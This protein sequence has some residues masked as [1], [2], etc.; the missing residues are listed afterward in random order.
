MA[1]IHH[2]KYIR[3]IATIFLALGILLASSGFSVSLHL[4]CGQVQSISV[5]AVADN[6]GE[7][8]MPANRVEPGACCQDL[9][10]QSQSDDHPATKSFVVEKTFAMDGAFPAAMAFVPNSIPRAPNV[11]GAEYSPPLI[12]RDIPVLVQSFLI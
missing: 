2:V 5:Y 11:I 6:C 8:D 3:S 4:C 7:M 9:H 12:A 1:V 10:Y